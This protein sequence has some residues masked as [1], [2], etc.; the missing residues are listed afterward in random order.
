MI[1]TAARWQQSGTDSFKALKHF[2]PKESVAKA[3]LLKRHLPRRGQ[4]ATNTNT[5][6]CMQSIV[7]AI[8][9]AVMHI[10]ERHVG[11]RR[12]YIDDAPE[13]HCSNLAAA[14]TNIDLYSK[15]WKD[16]LARE[17]SLHIAVI[18][19]AINLT[20]PKSIKPVG[21]LCVLQSDGNHNFETRVW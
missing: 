18:L 3:V 16:Q 7:D 9:A 17:V 12:T 13:E 14:F 6:H 21:V 8:K 10:L 2:H 20:V 15:Q 19:K 11:Q 5:Q 1:Q 4:P